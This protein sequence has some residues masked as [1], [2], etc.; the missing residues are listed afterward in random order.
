MNDLDTAWGETSEA[1]DSSAWILSGFITFLHYHTTDFP[2]NLFSVPIGGLMSA[3][4]D[5]RRI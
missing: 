3:S 5:Q 4:V 2:L 1:E